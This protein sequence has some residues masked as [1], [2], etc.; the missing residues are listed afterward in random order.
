MKC[1]S[2]RFT[3]GRFAVGASHGLARPRRGFSQSPELGFPDYCHMVSPR[4][5]T[6]DLHQLHA[7]AH[8]GNLERVRPTAHQNVRRR[9]WFGL[10]DGA[11]LFRGGYR[12]APRAAQEAG[13]GEPLAVE[14]SDPTEI[15]LLRSMTQRS[16]QLACGL[17]PIAPYPEASVDDFL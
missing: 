16:N 17:I 6:P 5:E 4:R 12:F 1:G 3:R 11:G 15:G 2:P 9:P 7:P 8:S 10:H 13:K 14:A